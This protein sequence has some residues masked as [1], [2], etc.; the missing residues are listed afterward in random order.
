MGA[1]VQDVRFA[2]R[3]LLRRPGPTTVIV[4]TLALGIGANAAV[5][6]I[7][8]D[9]L[10]RPLPFRDAEN[11]VALS[12]QFPVQGEYNESLSPGLFYE[13]K[14]RMHVFEHAAILQTHS[15]T[16]TGDGPPERIRGVRTS[17]SCL[18]ILGAKPILGR[19]FA[20][21]E[22]EA[23]AAPGIVLSHALWQRR[24]GSDPSVIG[25]LLNVGEEEYT[26]IG[27]LE[28]SFPSTRA[29]LPMLFNPDARIDY[30]S[31]LEL[32][33]QNRQAHDR[34]DYRVLAR[35]APG[36]TLA[37]AKVEMNALAS[38]MR[39]EH[40]QHYS[41]E[42][43]FAIG[44]TPFLDPMVREVQPALRL[45]AG[46]AAVVLLIACAN[47]ANLLL[48]WGAGR[49]Q[50]IGMRLALGASRVR[51]M[52]QLL[53]ESI[54]LS[55]L[56]GATGLLLCSWGTS[57]LVAGGGKTIPRIGEVG[58][59][60][61]VLLFTL[62]LSILT[63]IVFG[64]APSLTASASR[65]N[66]TLRDST[67]GLLRARRSRSLLTLLPRMV[68]VAELG[69]S[70]VLLICAGLLTHSFYRV[71]CVDPGFSPE[72]VLSFQLP[73]NPDYPNVPGLPH[74]VGFYN[75]L[76]ERLAR[77][78]G[79][80]SVGGVSVLPL[81]P[82]E[83]TSAIA[84]EG[85]GPANNK[86]V[87]EAHEHAVL[88]DFFQT[89]KVPLLSGRYFDESDKA[90]GI[91]VAIVDE[92]LAERF[93]PDQNAIGKRM[94]GVGLGDDDSRLTVVGVVR[95][96]KHADLESK[97]GITYYRPYG[98][99]ASKWMH[100]V[101][102]TSSDPTGIVSAVA[103]EVWA[104]DANRPLLQV[105]SMEQRLADSLARRRFSMFLL[106]VFAGLALILAVV[107]LYAVL[108]HSVARDTREIGIRMALGARREDV[109]SAVLR[110]G[111][112]ITATGLAIG[113]VA[114][115]VGTSV[116][117]TL[118]FEVTATD[119][120]TFLGIPLLLGGIALLACYLPARRATKVDPMVALRCE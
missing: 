93:W 70:V 92:T 86:T 69:L 17:A 66:Q 34:R 57:V 40:P 32:G 11:L 105:A 31:P 65:P 112:A 109:H 46:A 19:L 107:G 38:R 3:M 84:G 39:Q 100:L 104:L 25:R 64:L 106:S 26:V 77:L 67:G 35:L 72:K 27:V 90:D 116:L 120:V 80:E 29:Y 23:G 49:R 30:W 22:H 103:N 94:K 12:S 61:P 68:V 95:A 75:Q 60:A 5:F 108:A 88:W 8:Y 99:W 53:T 36:V 48:A 47:V 81:E 44:V 111:L 33:D 96:V 79:V 10:L 63:G 2:A 83:S 58:S 15:F 97:T 82:G 89:L 101:I 7:V 71:L 13:I 51:I 113:M 62:A 56:G 110:H 115:L 59:H 24:F 87:A 18:S 85:C 50:E 21:G 1:L 9:V 45:L 55:L 4:L 91:P 119:P 37:E 20:P 54:V 102:R 41:P 98:Q 114:S 16:L 52:R 78:P 117:E 74:Y 43:D 42:E 6:G 118:L 73:E 76:Q 28:R 14:E